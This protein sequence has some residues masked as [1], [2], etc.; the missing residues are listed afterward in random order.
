[1]TEMCIEPV[2]E[3]GQQRIV[4]HKFSLLKK[5]VGAE[6]CSLVISFILGMRCATWTF[7]V[8]NVHCTAVV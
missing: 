1:M 3:E 8:D 2:I 4:I 6:V 5:D 7:K